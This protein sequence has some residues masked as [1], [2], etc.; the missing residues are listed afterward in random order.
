MWGVFSDIMDLGSFTI[1]LVLTS[2]V[3]P[4]E[5]VKNLCDR[6]GRLCQHGFQRHTRLKF[7]VL[8][9]IEDAVLK[10]CRDNH[11]I[12]GQFTGDH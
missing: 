12:V 9:E 4:F 8:S 5:S 7:A 3:L 11:F 1:V 6:L 10:H 2:K